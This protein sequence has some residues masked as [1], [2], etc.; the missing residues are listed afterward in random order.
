VARYQDRAIGGVQHAVIERVELE[1][2][3]D[4]EMSGGR[5]PVRAGYS[6]VRARC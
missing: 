2:Q 5:C 6:R 4:E 1:A 3:G